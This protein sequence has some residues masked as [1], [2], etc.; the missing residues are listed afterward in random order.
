MGVGRAAVASVVGR[1]EEGRLDDG[2]ED[3]LAVALTRSV[4]VVGDAVPVSLAVV[5]S[6]PVIGGLITLVGGT[7]SPD[8]YV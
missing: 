8:P 5:A 3:D 1:G 2:E 7:G 4:A 6:A